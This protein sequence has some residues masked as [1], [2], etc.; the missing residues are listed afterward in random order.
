M[1]L[2]GPPDVA[3][4]ESQ[5]NVKGLIKALR[6]RKDS[7]VR[8]TAALALGRIGDTRAVRPLI[9]ALKDGDTA[10]TALSEIGKPAVEALI[11]ALN[12]K[13]R[14]VRYLAVL[15][16]GKIGDSRAVEALIATLKDPDIDYP[17]V[18]KEAAAVLRKFGEASVKPLIAALNDRHRSVRYGAAK[19]LGEIGDPQAVEPLIA[20]LTDEDS[21]VRRGMVSA[22]GEFHDPRSVE[23][24][25]SALTDN[26]G[27]V[28]SYAAWALGKI[29][30]S[31]AIEPLI[32]ALKDDNVGVRNAAARALGK[33]GDS[34]AVEPLMTVF[35]DQECRAEAATA[36]G[37]IGDPRAIGPLVA[38]FEA[39]SFSNLE[40]WATDALTA[41]GMGTAYFLFDANEISTVTKDSNYGVYA[42]DRLAASISRVVDPQAVA[43][44]AKHGDLLDVFGPKD[45][46]KFGY[47]FEATVRRVNVGDSPIDVLKSWFTTGKYGLNSKYCDSTIISAL[48]SSGRL[49]VTLYLIGT[50]LFSSTVQALDEDLRALKCAG[51]RGVIMFEKNL[52]LK[53]DTHK[54]SL[55]LADLNLK[56]QTLRG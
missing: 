54:E 6:Y 19:V 33:I 24:L 53:L 13:R 22:L 44:I 41:L 51:Y 55:S 15:T 27:L 3:R 38:A 43:R 37:Q 32:A 16:L 29:G 17:K 5:R 31:R 46:L 40:K 30:D 8:R 9:A 18:G 36:L 20:A 47:N 28:R 50:Y 56:T 25:I 4:L 21:F 10:A 2:F 45:V 49:P 34:R 11:A 39:V 1:S 7:G 52:I 42:Q 35:K 23:P 14:E 48:R 12:D 26:D